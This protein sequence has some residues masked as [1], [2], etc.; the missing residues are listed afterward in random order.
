[1]IFIGKSF[2]FSCLYDN[3]GLPTNPSDSLFSLRVKHP[4]SLPR[5]L[6]TG[7]AA[8]ENSLPSPCILEEVRA[9]LRP[10]L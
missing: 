8:S 1:M 3:A 10:V 2:F 4:V 9:D 6:V 7:S 5:N